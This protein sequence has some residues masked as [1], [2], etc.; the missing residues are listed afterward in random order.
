MTGKEAA[1]VLVG[2]GNPL[3][4]MTVRADEEFLRRHHLHA[5]DA[6]LADDV[7][8]HQAALFADIAASYSPTYGAGGATLN[9]VRV[10]QWMLGGRG[11]G[12]AFLGGVGGDQVGE[13]LRAAVQR[14][15]VAARW[16]VS[17]SLPTG[18]CAAVITGQ[19]DDCRR[20]LVARTGAASHLTYDWLRRPDNWAVVTRSRCVYIGGFLFP[21][22]GPQNVRRLVSAA[23]SKERVI[24]MN[25]SA[26]Y[27]CRY[28]SDT[29]HDVMPFVDVLFGNETEAEEF[30][31]QRGL[32][33]DLHQRAL[34]TAR[35][36]TAGR[37]PRVVVFTRGARPTVVS[38]GETVAEYPITPV[39][40]E[41][42]RDTNGCGDAFVG[43]YLSRLVD[44][45]ELRECLRAGH[46][47]A[48]VV[49]QYWG[50]NYPAKC[51]FK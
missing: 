2:I 51:D 46:Y 13:T 44:G 43:G 37:R 23:S 12:G 20:S 32:A 28:F 29:T 47:A 18:V 1:A 22:C 38:D 40:P 4:D 11:A 10:A 5:D 41:C 15:G 48:S 33:G 9:S 50:C 6:V 14:D 3:L 25:L 26:P 7:D 35:L 31:S 36:P 42:V 39:A 24:A 8:A 17:A 30:C 45:R 19:G 21:T 16:R 49:T 34:L 27:L